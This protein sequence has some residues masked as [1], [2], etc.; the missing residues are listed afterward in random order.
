MKPFYCLICLFLSISASS[1]VEISGT[2]IS[3]KGI[4]VNGA[5]IYIDGRYDGCTSDSLGNFSFR[6]DLSSPQQLIISFVG[7]ETFSTILNSGD[8][9]AGLKIVMK[10]V[11]G[12]IDEVV[13]NAGTFEAGG[14]KKSVVLTPLDVALTPGANGDV[15]G[16]FSTLPGSQKVGEEGRLF[17][18][19]GEGYETKT[20]MDGMQVHTPYFSKMPDLPTRGRFSPLLFSGSVFST[21]GYSAEFGQAL[22]SIVALNTNALEPE[23]KS[24]ISVIS[25]GLQGSHARR[26]KNTSLALTGEMIHTGLS[27]KIFRQNVE[28]IKEPFLTGST[29]MFRHKTGENGMIKSFVGFSYNS[30]S[31]RYNNFREADLQD[32]TLN[33]SNVYFNTTYNDMI[34][35]NWMV[36]TGLAWN[37]DVE[38]TKLGDGFVKTVKEGGQVKA[39]FTHFMTEKIQFKT[40]SDFVFNDYRQLIEMDGEYRLPFTNNQLSAFVEIELKV[41]G[42]FAVRAG[43]RAE[44]SSLPDKITLMPR[45]SSALKSGKFSQFSLAFGTFYQNPED[46]Y[47][48]FSPSLMPEKA[49]HSILTFQFKKDS[50]TLRLEAYSKK[51][52]GLVKFTDEYSIEPG[53]Y[54]NSGSGYSNGFDVFWRD[55]KPFGKSD[56]WISYSWNDSQRN[57]RNYPVQSAPYYASE[58]NLS[59]VYK[60]FFT[61]VNLF[62]AATY[63]FAS[64]RHYYNPNNPVFMGDMTRPYNDLSLSITHITYL[65]NT[66]TVIHLVVNNVPGFKNIFGYTYSESSNSRGIYE[67]KPIT[68]PSKRMAVL[69]ISFQL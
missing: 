1:Q 40:G 9:T 5:N 63:A 61:K 7:F 58:H 31:L 45:I 18:R 48:K 24:S 49:I 55:Q 59:V 51:Y 43:G 41:S 67:E 66:Q 13:I 47:L 50:K 26:W 27:N 28:W 8:K 17:V 22:S 64:G 34:G 68:P 4:P 44:Y 62:G 21:G 2:V 23:D 14:R 57:Y 37:T 15:F 6:T 25:V 30:S 38:N 36:Q 16:A 33:N 35:E 10:E 54:N 29:L 65:F 60:K 52:S 46:D 69:L 3:G 20:F 53:N 42:K 11:A 32:L 56:Y 12:E 39:C 19:G